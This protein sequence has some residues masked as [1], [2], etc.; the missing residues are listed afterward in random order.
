MSSL[1]RSSISGCLLS[2]VRQPCGHAHAYRT[3]SRLH[4]RSR[5][6]LL[7]DMID[8][9]QLPEYAYDIGFEHFDKEWCEHWTVTDWS[10]TKAPEL[11]T[12]IKASVEWYRSVDNVYTFMLRD[13]ICTGSAFT[14]IAGP[15]WSIKVGRMK[16]VAVDSKNVAL[17]TATAVENLAAVIAS[18]AA[19]VDE[20]DD[21]TY[22][23]VDPRHPIRR[24][25]ATTFAPL[26]NEWARAPAL[27]RQEEEP[28]QAEEEA[29]ERPAAQRRRLPQYD[30]PGD[31]QE[32]GGGGSGGGSRGGGSDGRS[33]GGSGGG[34]GEDAFDEDDDFD[35]DDVVVATNAARAEDDEDDEDDEEGLA[36]EAGAD[37]GV[38]GPDPNE[39]EDGEEVD[40]EEPLNSDD[41]EDDEDERAGDGA[42]ADGAVG[43]L[44]ADVV[45]LVLAQFDKVRRTGEL[46]KLSLRAGTAHLVIEGKNNHYAFA[47]AD[48]EFT[49]A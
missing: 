13:A 45:N 12:S 19:E 37:D 18:D 49:F 23:L 39:V 33:G 42:L 36:P 2:E 15:L 21:L 27:D 46:W 14:G 16:L 25:A 24:V 47:R 40:E 3:R 22:G 30:G 7:T 17:A 29:Y 35:D 5:A 31:G 43:P 4:C 10:E 48:C 9:G 11:K 32:G 34:G 28:W 8:N 38:L 41:D 6:Q 1:Y 20:H 44:N 26:P